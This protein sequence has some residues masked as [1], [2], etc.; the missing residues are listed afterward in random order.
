MSCND[1]S[2]NDTPN[3]EA[4]DG[5]GTSHR[6]PPLMY[7][8]GT[9]QYPVDRNDAIISP[10]PVRIYLSLV[11]QDP[12][13]R[14]DNIPHVDNTGI[15]I[16]NREIGIDTTAVT[17]DQVNELDDR[18]EDLHV[19]VYELQ[20]S[21]ARRLKLSRRLCGLSLWFFLFS[22]LI[23]FLIYLLGTKEFWSVFD[24]DCSA[25]S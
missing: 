19:I 4:S 6:R 22:L 11:G 3:R 9:T 8:I 25:D 15:A 1:N 18:I 23:W 7:I 20:A 17:L 12:I 5:E 14:V 24:L 21:N 16:N 2:N 13:P 10:Q